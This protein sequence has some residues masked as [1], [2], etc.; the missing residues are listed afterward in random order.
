MWKKNVSLLF[1]L[2][3]VFSLGRV[4][5]AGEKAKVEDSVIVYHE[6][7]RFGGWP[8]NHGIW[9]W[10]DE[11][12]VG[13]SAAYFMRKP[14]DRHQ[15][16]S[17]KH[18]EPRLARSLDGG[19]T[20][21]IEAPKSLLPPEQGGL[22]V[23]D[24]REPMDFTDPNFVMTLRF[25]HVDAGPSYLY[26]STDRGVNW[27]GPYNFPLF[28][29]QGVAA[30]TDYVINGKRDALVFLTAAKTNGREGRPFCVRTT[31]GGLTWRMVSWIGPEPAGF[32]IMPSTVRLSPKILLTAV[33][34]KEEA[35]D[36]I[37]LYRS[38]DD[39]ATWKAISRPVPFT[40]GRSGNPPSMIRLK[41]GRLCLTY[42]YRG[43]PYGVRARLSGDEGRT[44]SDEIILRDDGASWDLGYPRTVQRPDGK[45]VTVYYFAER[46]DR[47]RDI[48]A[49]IWDAGAAQK[50]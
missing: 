13:F 17:D 34:C 50:R 37:D 39:G 6:A 29:R 31:D 49:T 44:W 22:A 9:S 41:D 32:T 1:T 5:P 26:Y 3:A 15:Y 43:A 25:T 42:G 27:R 36:W 11:I 21:K 46:Q 33:R 35:R 18:E 4:T 47:E 8:A 30:R 20:W 48:V 23:S 12:L 24:L 7:G 45:I 2:L 14:P 28:D 16:D 38:D 10:G 19:R 40:G